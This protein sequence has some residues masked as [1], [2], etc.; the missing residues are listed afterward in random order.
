[1]QTESHGNTE[2]E[3][4]EEIIRIREQGEAIQKAIDTNLSMK[5]EIQELA[6]DFNKSGRQLCAV[7][8]NAGNLSLRTQEVFR[9]LQQEL[10][11]NSN[12]KLVVGDFTYKY[13]DRVRKLNWEDSWY[14]LRRVLRLAEKRLDCRIDA[15][16][17]WYQRKLPGVHSTSQYLLL[18]FNRVSEAETVKYLL[19]SQNHYFPIFDKNKQSTHKR[20]VVLNYVDILEEEKRIP[21]LAAQTAFELYY[22]AAMFAEKYEVDFIRKCIWSRRRGNAEFKIA[23]SLSGYI[24]L[25][26]CY[27]GDEF[28]NPIWIH[29]EEAMKRHY[30]ANKLEQA[31]QIQQKSA[32]D[33]NARKKKRTE[34][35][36]SMPLQTQPLCECPVVKYGNILDQTTGKPMSSLYISD[37]PYAI[38]F[39]NK[40]DFYGTR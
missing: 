24:P 32:D 27:V 19:S 39:L 6:D 15:E 21:L 23:Y 29:W 10:R 28:I 7:A 3:I 38:H 2:A 35:L 30:G 20:L 34:L 11:I 4:E 25:A 1:M 26:R 5:K 12:K 36:L 40:K 18:E 33:E 37:F 16:S 17:S 9:T 14:S 31:M 8:E 22:S 13:K